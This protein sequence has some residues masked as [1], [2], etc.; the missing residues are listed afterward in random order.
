[1]YLEIVYDDANE[2]HAT[3]RATKSEIAEV[4][5]DAPTYTR[6]RTNGSIGR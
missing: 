4:I 5:S 6:E 2:E 1:V 3:R